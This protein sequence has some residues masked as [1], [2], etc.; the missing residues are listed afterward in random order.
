ME[1]ETT[2]VNAC[3]ENWRL[4]QTL[5]PSNWEELATI[6]GA[7]KRLRGFRSIND[8]LR[9]LLLHVGKGY[10]L[11]E[12]VTRSKVAG[13]ADISDVALLKRLRNSEHWLRELCLSLL[14]KGNIRAPKQP[15][16][17]QMRLVDGTVV[18]EQGAT[19]S[20]WRFLYSFRV[21]DFECDYFRLTP[22]DGVGNGESFAYL[23]VKPGDYIMGD[24]GYCNI[25][26]IEHITKAKASVLVRM[27][28]VSLPVFGLD[29]KRF[30]F[31]DELKMLTEPFKPAAWDVFV[32]GS[33]LTIK[34]RIC[35]IRK[36]DYAIKLA[37]K[38]L[39]R[40]ASKDG[41][42]LQPETLE[43][44]K[45]V[46]V[47]TTFPEEVFDSGQILQW[48]RLRWQVELAFKRMKSLAQLG[49]LP[50]YD[51]ASSRAWL[52][53]KLFIALLTEELIRYAESISPWGYTFIEAKHLA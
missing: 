40:E 1:P 14:K 37:E 5:F 42:T 21:P 23:P 3:E 7:N 52:Y 47:F 13:L 53:G 51:E 44:L 2:E 49:Q 31:V 24:R 10:S 12:T 9:I 16:G 27:N 48:Y 15:K 4:L 36:S 34:G 25:N 46:I 26:G 35:A 41:R 28:P 30:S 18:N 8:V 29:S 45:Y 43:L 50:K 38:R 22:A 33:D 39:R 11:R 32:K 6:T 17:I 19:G 20:S